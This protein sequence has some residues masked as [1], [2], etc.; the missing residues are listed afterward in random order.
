MLILI[1]LILCLVIWLGYKHVNDAHK[2][3]LLQKATKVENSLSK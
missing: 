3:A 2:K 1:A